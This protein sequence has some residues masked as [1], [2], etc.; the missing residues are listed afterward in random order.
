LLTGSSAEK[1]RK[2]DGSYDAT[3]RALE[4]VPLFVH[5]FDL[6]LRDR[7]LWIALPITSPMRCHS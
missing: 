1:R 2:L 7:H 5:W 6:C 3:I 4:V